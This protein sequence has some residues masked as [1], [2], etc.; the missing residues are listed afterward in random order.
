MGEPRAITYKEVKKAA[1][2]DQAGGLELWHKIG[3][4][5]GAGHLPGQDEATIDLT[6]VSD[7]KRERIDKLLAGEKEEVS[8]T[9]KRGNK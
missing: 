7:A 5:T 3:E 1:G 8:E 2:N 6:G 4:I 9:T